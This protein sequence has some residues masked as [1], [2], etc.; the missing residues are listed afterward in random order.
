MGL[1]FEGIRRH[2]ELRQ[3]LIFVPDD[4]T[5]HAGATKPT[6]DP[7]ETD[8][9]IIREV[10]VKASSGARVG[11]WEPT[12]GVDSYRVRRLVGRWVEEGA[13]QPVA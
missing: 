5:L 1:L 12:I 7:E 9:A 11:D 4:L 6:P 3:M 8:P 10:W 2:D 13:L